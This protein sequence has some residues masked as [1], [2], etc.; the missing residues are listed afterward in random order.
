VA[1]IQK[2]LHTLKGNSGTIGLMRI[3]EITKDIEIPAKV[4]NLDGFQERTAILTKEFEEFK[5]KYTK[6]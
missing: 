2:E 5:A 4:G 6:I 3:H 1:T